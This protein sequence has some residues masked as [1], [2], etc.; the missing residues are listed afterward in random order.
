MSSDIRTSS[1]AFGTLAL[2]TVTPT[3]SK[4]SKVANVGFKKHLR[5]YTK[6]SELS[7]TRAVDLD[8]PKPPRAVFLNF[9]AI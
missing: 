1:F 7:D 9:M 2:T 4:F 5:N 8:E 6:L 3:L